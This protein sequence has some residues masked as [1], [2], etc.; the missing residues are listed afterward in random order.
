MRQ[1]G[2]CQRFFARPMCSNAIKD[3]VAL[4]TWEKDGFGYAEGYDEKST[5]ATARCVPVSSC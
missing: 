4:T 2:A 5:P 1:T 3:G